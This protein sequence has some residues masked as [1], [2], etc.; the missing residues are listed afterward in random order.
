MHL[1]GSRRLILVPSVL[2][3]LPD[4]LHKHLIRHPTSLLHLIID[5]LLEQTPM[6]PLVT[7]LLHPRDVF[8]FCPAMDLVGQS[9]GGDHDDVMQDDHGGEIDGLDRV[10]EGGYVGEEEWSDLLSAS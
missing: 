8:C 2:Q 7:V 3:N 9:E 4:E 6:F 5:R 1:P 10:G